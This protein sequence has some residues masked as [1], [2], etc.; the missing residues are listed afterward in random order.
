MAEADYDLAYGILM[1]GATNHFDLRIRFGAGALIADVYE[2][3]LTVRDQPDRASRGLDTSGVGID[4][5]D[6]VGSL[7]GADGRPD[8]QR[9]VE[10]AI[11]V[12]L[13]EQWHFARRFF[14]AGELAGYVTAGVSGGIDPFLVAKKVREN[15]KQSTP[16]RIPG[17]L[18]R[19]LRQKSLTEDI[20]KIFSRKAA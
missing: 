13:V 2:E 12:A 1:Y 15:L 4:E 6:A 8:A 10:P 11:F 3:R 7:Y 14:L 5:K 18:I 20:I 9:R 17:Q 16:D 19:P